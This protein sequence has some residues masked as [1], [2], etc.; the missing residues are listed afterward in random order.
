MSEAELS[1]VT[2]TRDYIAVK[3]G[4]EVVICRRDMRSGKERIMPL[5]VDL[6]DGKIYAI[7]RPS[8]SGGGDAL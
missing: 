2:T 8:T 3:P 1:Y 5:R 6:R 4:G 7:E